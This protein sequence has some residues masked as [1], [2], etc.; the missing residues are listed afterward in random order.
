MHSREVQN[1]PREPSKNV[2]ATQK[3][4]MHMLYQIPRFWY[5]APWC[6][7]WLPGLIL[8]KPPCSLTSI[9]LIWGL[10]EQGWFWRW[11]PRKLCFWKSIFQPFTS[12]EHNMFENDFFNHLALQDK[13][14][15]KSFFESPSSPEQ[16]FWNELLSHL[17]PPKLFFLKSVIWATLLSK[18]VFLKTVL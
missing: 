2:F 5:N 16:F 14:F 7:K 3:W 13:C 4:E 10:S 6:Q 9:F 11:T 8:I 12:P 17:A 15:R 1:D 18:S